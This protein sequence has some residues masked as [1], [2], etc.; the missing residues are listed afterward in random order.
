MQEQ[1]K[2]NKNKEIKKAQ[3]GNKS[4]NVLKMN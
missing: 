2:G 4:E 1:S 3:K